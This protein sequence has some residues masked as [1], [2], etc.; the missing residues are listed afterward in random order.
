MYNHGLRVLLF[1]FFSYILNS[2]Y[3]ILSATEMMGAGFLIVPLMILVVGGLF[4]MISSTSK[5]CLCV[6]RRNQ[7][8]GRLMVLEPGNRSKD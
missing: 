1:S 5:L 3:F 8:F 6:C 2:V 4:T 7:L